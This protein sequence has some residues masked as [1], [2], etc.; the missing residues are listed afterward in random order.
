VTLSDSSTPTSHRTR[1]YLPTSIHHCELHLALFTGSGQVQGVFHA[2]ID[3][4][5]ITHKNVITVFTTALFWGIFRTSGIFTYSPTSH[6]LRNELIIL[7][8]TPFSLSFRKSLTG[9]LA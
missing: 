3:I 9:L 4:G 5:D 7:A 6:E 8:R 1:S 2:S